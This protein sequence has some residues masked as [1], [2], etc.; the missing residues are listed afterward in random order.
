MAMIS[1]IRAIRKRVKAV[2]WRWAAELKIRAKR[3]PSHLSSS[4]TTISLLRRACQMRALCRFGARN[5]KASRPMTDN[6][7]IP[8]GA[9]VPS[10]TASRFCAIKGAMVRF[11]RRSARIAEVE[12]RND[13]FDLVQN[14]V[15][16]AVTRA[17]RARIAYRRLLRN[18]SCGHGLSGVLG[19]AR[20]G[21]RRGKETAAKK[22]RLLP[23]NRKILYE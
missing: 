2:W 19:D 11:Y 21:A 6:C 4:P 7:A 3:Q 15:L 23:K 16:D 18:P 14:P 8:S 22:P 13:D 9:S 17:A 5:R 1:S 20:R 12:V 10:Q